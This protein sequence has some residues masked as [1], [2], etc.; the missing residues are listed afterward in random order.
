MREDVEKGGI[1]ELNQ[2][3]DIDKIRKGA[4][5]LT[6]PTPSIHFLL[7]HLRNY[8]INVKK[9][10]EEELLRLVYFSKFSNFYISGERRLLR[11]IV[12]YNLLYLN[13]IEERD[14]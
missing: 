2:F 13:F 10:P 8:L 5:E 9:S 6:K 12:S 1:Q 7:Y 4:R 11:A 14:I 3:Q